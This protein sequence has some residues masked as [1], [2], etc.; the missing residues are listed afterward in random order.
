ME[1]GNPMPGFPGV[2]PYGPNDPYAV[3]SGL[4][5]GARVSVDW[6]EGITAELQSLAPDELPTPLDAAVALQIALHSQISPAEEHPNPVNVEKGE[7]RT[8]RISVGKKP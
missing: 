5:N 8:I 6:P 1:K 3:P 7:P 4:T 2:L